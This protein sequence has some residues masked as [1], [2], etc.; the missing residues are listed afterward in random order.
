MSKFEVARE[1]H[2][3]VDETYNDNNAAEVLAK[4]SGLPSHSIEEYMIKGAVWHTRKGQTQRL[5]KVDKT[6][7]T[8]DELH[9]YYNQQVLNEVPP[10][11]T[12]LADEHAYSVWYKPYGMY[13]Q[14]SK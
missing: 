9:L 11:A 12:I 7:K 8:G 6:L 4:I 3:V 14:G 5:R 13:C 1:F 2:Q 10:S